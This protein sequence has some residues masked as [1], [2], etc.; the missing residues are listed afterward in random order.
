[1]EESRKKI[2]FAINT[3][4]KTVITGRTL[5]QAHSQF[6]SNVVS[7]FCDRFKIECLS[8]LLK[9]VHLK[10]KMNFVNYLH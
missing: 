6:V 1:M 8:S 10:R 4:T 5:T 9:K 2:L 3:N 7:N